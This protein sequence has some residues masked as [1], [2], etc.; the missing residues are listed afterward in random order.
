MSLF[1][2]S[3]GYKPF[4]YPWLMEAASDHYIERFWHEKQIDLRSDVEQW[5]KKDG[6]AVAGVSH[7]AN[8][9]LITQGLNMFTASD[10]AVGQVYCDVL[11][12]AFKNNEARAWFTTV[13][14]QEGVHQRAYALIPETLKFGDKSFQKFLEYTE[15]KNKWDFFTEKKGNSYTD[16]AFTLFKLAMI[17]GISLFGL[18]CMLRNFERYGLML[19]MNTV[20]E[21]SVIDENHHADVN[22][23]IFR[24]MI[25]E[26]K[27]INTEDFR[28]SL[29]ELVRK[30]VELEDQFIDLAFALGPQAGLTADEVKMFIRYLADKRLIQAGLQPNFGVKRNPLSW[31]SWLVDAPSHSNFF[32]KRV[33]DYDHAGLVGNIDYSKYQIIA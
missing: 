20:V 13:A 9:N 4:K 26:H 7:E 21:W 27:R 1:E 2:Y 31:M 12:P 23:Q 16:I 19:G 17:E 24:Q 3:V 30:L 29:Y 25:S 6:L 10:V 11:I 5:Y 32:E 18:F 15:T 22:I 28:K 14:A 33:V 8:K